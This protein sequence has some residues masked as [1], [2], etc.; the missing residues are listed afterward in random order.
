MIAKL[1][2]TSD[3]RTVLA[4]CDSNLIGRKIVEGD[5]QLD[6]SS[7][8]YKGEEMSVDR[9]RE[10]FKVVNII[11][12]VGEETVKIGVNEGIVAEV[13]RIGGVPHAEVV[14]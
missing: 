1:H 7:N 14:V 3:G 9:I 5:L 6:L 11:N 8:F 12:L 2:K 10:L 13:K 4:V